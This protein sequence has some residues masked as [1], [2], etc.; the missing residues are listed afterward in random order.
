MTPDVPTGSPVQSPKCDAT[1]A[2]HLLPCKIDSR[3]ES[4]PK[5]PEIVPPTK[6]SPDPT[7]STVSTCS[8]DMSNL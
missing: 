3:I 4:P 5:I 8:G 1:R 6:A 2:P 7:G